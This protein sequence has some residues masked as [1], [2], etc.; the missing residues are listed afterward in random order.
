MKIDY[1]I[2][3]TDG[4]FDYLSPW[5]T[6][7]CN[8]LIEHGFEFD[9][10]IGLESFRA[11]GD[12]SYLNLYKDDIERLIAEL[13]AILIDDYDEYAAEVSLS[14]VIEEVMES[15]REIAIKEEMAA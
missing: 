2:K 6:S 13:D 4:S 14:E 15:L 3:T 7:T 12:Y 10:A 5:G 11:F 8:S 9:D 1:V